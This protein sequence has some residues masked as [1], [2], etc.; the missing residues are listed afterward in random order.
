MKHPRRFSV[1]LLAVFPLPL[2]STLQVGGGYIFGLPVGFIADSLGSTAGATA[3]FLVGKTVSP[4]P[5]GLS[6]AAFWGT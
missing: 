5:L 2:V 4:R 1:L 3:A 6:L